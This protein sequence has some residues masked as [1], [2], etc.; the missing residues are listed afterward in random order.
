MRIPA[1]KLWS[2]EAHDQCVSGDSAG[3][4]PP[5]IVVIYRLHAGALQGFFVSAVGG[6]VWASITRTEPIRD[7]YEYFQNS[8]LREREPFKCI[9]DSYIYRTMPFAPYR[10]LYGDN[11]KRIIE[12]PVRARAPHNYLMGLLWAKPPASTA[13]FHGP[14][15]TVWSPSGFHD[16]GPCGS[17]KQNV[18]L[19]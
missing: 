17:S 11:I 19:M 14:P 4:C 18:S 16:F 15:Y 2:H 13:F 12:K 6:S 10:S 3:T 5:E 1:C 7:P 9:Q 8:E